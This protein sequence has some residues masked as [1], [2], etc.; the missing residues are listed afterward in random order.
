MALFQLDQVFSYQ[1]A[2]DIKRLWANASAPATPGDGEV[3][4][5][6]ST[7][8]I[9][10]KR[11]KS[12]NGTWETI[13]GTTNAELLAA[14]KNVDGSGSG[15]DADLLDGQE[16]TF[17]RNAS[18]L[19]AGTVPLACIPTT[20]TG[21]D[22]DKLDGQDGS[23][24]QNGSNI[25]A[26]TIS[27]DR[28][29]AEAVRTDTDAIISANTRW[30][31]DKQMRAGTDNDL[32]IF[33]SSTYDNTYLD[34]YTGDF[35]FRQLSNGNNMY[36][37]AKDTSGTL[38]SMLTLDPDIPHAKF[39]SLISMGS[40]TALV[41][42]NGAITISKSYHEIDT[43]GGASSDDLTNIN[44]GTIGSLLLLRSTNSARSVRLRNG[45]GNLVLCGDFTLNSSNDV[46]V[47][48]NKDS[49]NWIEVTRSDNL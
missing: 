44:G 16:G 47:L 4:L 25:N 39:E 22:A 11:Y 14:L 20:L 3:W 17:Y 45:V 6:L 34:N 19:N 40:P 24:Y 10:L 37:Q 28:L 33:H 5:D 41:I 32:R 29:P 7:T 15:L 36:L 21:K 49:V 23:F 31:D 30:V 12:S 43:E 18:N 42:S 9:K 27:K 13:A 46:I 1:D 8:P 48:Y 2:N 35:Y 38:K 26:G